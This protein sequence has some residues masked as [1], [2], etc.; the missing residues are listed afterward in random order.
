MGIRNT[1]RA[2]RCRI[3]A[4]AVAATVG[5]VASGAQGAGIPAIETKD[6]VAGRVG[7]FKNGSL[8]TPSGGGRTSQAGDHAADFGRSNTGPVYVADGAFL[9]DSTKNNELAVSF[10]QK[11]YDVSDGSSFWFNSTGSNNGNRGFQAHVPWSN[12]NVYFDT[13]GCCGADTQRINAG[14]DTF[15]DYTG[16]ATWWQSWHHFVFSKKGDNKQVWI[17]GKLF[18]E[19]VNSAP[20]PTDFTDLGIGGQASVGGGGQA[21]MLHGVL[22]D[23]AIYGTALNEASIA[24]LAKGDSPSTLAASDKLVAFWDFNDLPAA[25]MFVSV[26]P[27][28]DTSAANPDGIRVV[29]VDGAEAWTQ[30]NVSLK[31]DGVAVPVTMTKEGSTATLTYKASPLWAMQSTHTASLTYPAGGGQTAT[32]DW[33]FT[34]GG[35]TKDSVAT[36]IGSFR[37]AS[38]SPD[39]KGRSSKAGDRAADFGNGKGSIFVSDASFLNAA[40][41]NN[42]MSFSLWINKLNIAASSSFWANSPSSGGG[43]GWQAHIPW[44]NNNI[45]FDTAGCCGADTERINASLDTFGD[46]TGDVTWWNTWHHLVFSKKGDT[47]QIWINGKL[48]LEGVNTDPLPTDFTTMFIGADGNGGGIMHGMIDDFAVYGTALTEAQAVS[49]AG[50]AAPGSLPASAKLIASWDFNDFPPDG[51][52]VSFAPA[53]NATAAAPNGIQV[54]HQEGSAPWDPKKVSLELDGTLVAATVTQVDGVTTVKYTPNPLLAPLSKHTAKIIY[55][56]GASTASKEWSFTVGVYTKDSVASYVGLLQGAAKY[57]A[58]AGG[59]SGKA[60]DYAIDFGAANAGQSVWINDASFLN[61]AS[62]KDEMAIAAWQKLYAIADS[63]MFWGVSPSSGGGQRGF[64]VHTPWSNNTIYFD[65]SGCCGADTQRINAGIDTFGDYTG[66][67]TWWQSWHH[68]IFQKKGSTKEIWIDGKLFL[69]GENTAVLPSDFTEAYLAYDPPDNARLRGFL[70]DFA[71]FGTALDEATAQKLANRTATPASLPASQ[72]LIAY[73]NFNDVPST[74][75]AGPKIMVTRS[76][77]SLTIGS[78]PQPLPAGF[79]LE[80]AN[81]ITGPW[82]PQ[83]GATT[84]VTVQINPATSGV[85]LRAVKR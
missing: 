9:N 85:Y 13:A 30:S 10:W 65:T 21:N 63:A 15:P 74:P 68:L 32:V 67:Q 77:N 62:S 7:A 36:R 66:D 8:F 38:Y 64:S 53:A 4:A 54:V 48:F 37:G 72:K 70:D 29:H 60:G 69:S 82:V 50:G 83:V 11:R 25:G 44:N 76:G 5:F 73:W 78:D 58:D 39:G 16:D 20:L 42:E 84:P 79:V 46:Y 34:V 49:L 71:V 57:T 18:F 80:I 40:A 6:K 56:V 3:T 52:F 43:R 22:D 26:S 45:Y 23:F 61:Q 41:A 27:A 51:L 75:V 59:A 28:P 14:I 17:D 47:K 24:K 19:G 55:P 81:S 33:S 12:A 2:H 1:K 31:V 35:Y